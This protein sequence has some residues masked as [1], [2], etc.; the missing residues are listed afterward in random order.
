M[1]N[2]PLVFKVKAN[3]YTVQRITSGNLMRIEIAKAQ[4][5]NNQYGNIL[6]NRT[7]WS[8]H[9]LDMVDMF[10]HLIV[11][12]P[13]LVEDLKVDTWE[14][15]DP[16]DLEELSKTYKEQFVPWFVDFTEILR[17]AKS[18]TSNADTKKK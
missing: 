7:V 5:T 15:L 6:A 18:T 13:K 1:Y 12:F 16:F 17:K 4:L 11:F 9:V 2:K 3:T 10:A 8:E 14:E